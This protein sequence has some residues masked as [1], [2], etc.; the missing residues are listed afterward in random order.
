MSL[1]FIPLQTST[2]ELYF[3]IM[4]KCFILLLVGLTVLSADAQTNIEKF[5]WLTPEKTYTN[6]QDFW[7]DHKKLMGLSD[8]NTFVMISA[9][10]D[11]VGMYHEKYDQYYRGVKI[12]GAQFIL[13][14]KNGRVQSANGRLV[15]GLKDRSTPVL[16]FNQA[17]ESAKS[18]IQTTAFYWEM[19]EMEELIKDIYADPSKTFYPKEEL[20]Y[21]DPKF[22]QDGSQ[23]QLAYLLDMYYEGEHDHQEMYISA[24]TGELI[25]TVDGCHNASAN[26]TAVTRYHGTVDITAHRMSP[27]R[28]ILLDTTRGGGI[29]TYDM[30]QGTSFGN[31][32]DFED[33]DNYWNNANAQIDEVAGDVHWSTEMTYDYLKDVHNRNS[34]DNQGTKIMSYV[35][36]RRNWFNASWNDRFA[37]YG[38]G[39]GNPLT[40]IDVIAHELAHGVTGT[41]AG[42][43]YQGE[44]G[45]LNESFSDIFGA[46]VEHFAPTGNKDWRIGRSNFTLRD[47]SNPAQFNDPST[48]RGSYWHTASSDNGGVHTNS[49]VQNFWFYVLV[50]GAKGRND[51][52][53]DYDV[54]GIGWTKAEK[55]A[56]RNLTRYLTRSS[57]YLDARNGA[58]QAAKDLYGNC[59]LEANATAAAWHA[60]GIGNP[61]LTDDVQLDEVLSPLGGCSLSNAETVSVKYHYEGS[62]C[63]NTI[64]AGD[65]IQFGYRLNGGNAV[66]ENHILSQP[67]TSGG[68]VNYTFSNKLDLSSKGAYDLNVFLNYNNDEYGVNDSV[69]DFT[70]KHQDKM[71]KDDYLSFERD[72]EST[73]EVLYSAYERSNSKAY[74]FGLAAN[75]GSWG[76]VLTGDDFDISGHSY[77]PYEEDNFD[78]D[79]EFVSKLCA[80]VDAS[81]YGGVTLEF[82]L[83]QTYSQMHASQRG[84]N[85]PQNLSSMRLVV[86]DTSIGDQYHPKTFSND[87]F[88][89]HKIV[90]DDYGKSE[91]T[92]CFEGKHFINTAQETQSTFGDNS[93][94]DNVKFTFSEA[95]TVASIAESNGISSLSLF[96]NPN[97]GTFELI[98][99]QKAPEKISVLNMKG[100][101]VFEQNITE[102]SSSIKSIDLEGVE[103]GVYLLQA[104]STNGVESLRF[105]IE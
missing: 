86:N 79:T 14:Y 82:D 9:E 1:K 35:H 15:E 67:L 47:M 26:G 103:P 7:K 48:Y 39:N 73:E 68:T 99:G 69:L 6:G 38:D 87:P 29:Q 21:I 57:Q 104:I 88:V 85:R 10:D 22:T 63:N 55:I 24:T 27:T 36:V 83:R 3:V 53:D 91:F 70:V 20:V 49:G 66:V 33:A 17:L 51:N 44:S 32:V 102:E 23:Y 54:S 81:N 97:N 94:I 77:W 46:A 13:H 60:A 96:P 19:E 61:V 62:G 18:K 25:H 12:D 75:T 72:R 56:Y 30:N 90:L 16:N 80:C 65:T 34:W 11:Q 76:F 28:Y 45:A 42:L 58:V 52:G 98:W 93:F 41:S 78:R 59:S 100:Q 105:V 74:K 95:S 43:I 101:V 8:Q 5:N 37:Q 89:T 31:A 4:R 92:L 50:E 71:E 40:S 84:F 2:L 64:P